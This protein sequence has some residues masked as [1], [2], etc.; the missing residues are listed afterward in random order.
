MKYV[1]VPLSSIVDKIDIH[2]WYINNV[3]QYIHYFTTIDAYTT[4]VGDFYYQKSLILQ[5]TFTL[6]T[7]FPSD[8]NQV[9][10]LD[11]Y[12]YNTSV[13][14]DYWDYYWLAIMTDD[15]NKIFSTQLAPNA[16]LS[17][18]LVFPMLNFNMF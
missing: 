14:D 17:L 4:A 16:N 2:L 7:D 18:S 5:F 1:D 11:L 6:P 9:Y 8:I 15:P 13:S 10:E 12:L 3:G